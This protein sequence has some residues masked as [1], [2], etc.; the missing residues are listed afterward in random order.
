MS[1]S[2]RGRNEDIS[3]LLYL[4]P[5]V[6]S[7]VYAIFLWVRAGVT[8]ILPPSVYLTVTRDPILFVVGSLAVLLAV[9]LEVTSTDSEGRPSKVASVSNTLQ[10]IALASL[11]LAFLSAL[12]SNGFLDLSGAAT[13]FVVGRYALVFPA[14]L[15]LFSYLVRAQFRIDALLNRKTL[16]IVSLLLVPA[17]LYVIGKRQP[18]LG[19]GVAFVFL[20]IGIIPFM[21][22]TKK[23][24]GTEG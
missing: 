1:S 22:P 2:S 4:V 21:L 3:A 20:L 16:G 6:A 7:G 9:V 11:V 14:V 17:S 5:F 19:L 23:V 24:K 8:A 10:S 18:A 12:Y 15:I 13:D